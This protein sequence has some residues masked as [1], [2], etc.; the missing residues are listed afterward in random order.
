GNACTQVDTCKAGACTGASPVSCKASDQCHSAGTCDPT[1][2]ICSNPAKPDGTACDDG[3]ACTALDGCHAGT[4]TG[5]PLSSFG[6]GALVWPP[7]YPGPGVF[8]HSPQDQVSWSLTPVVVGGSGRAFF[9][10]VYAAIGASPYEPYS[11]VVYGVD[12]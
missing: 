5:S 1:T 4:C 7:S 9:G 12:G 2:G 11:D 10:L 8:L 6:A 3:N